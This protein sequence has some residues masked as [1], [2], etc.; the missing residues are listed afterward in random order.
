MLGIASGSLNTVVGVKK[1]AGVDIVLSI[2]SKRAIPS[3]ITYSD[4]ERNYGDQAQE[5]QKSK[6]NTTINYPSRLLGFQPEWEGFQNECKYSLC[7]PTKNSTTDRASYEID[8]KGET[9]TIYPEGAMGTFLNKLKHLFENV[10]TDNKDISISVPD[11][12]TANERQAMIDAVR[13]ADLKL[14]QLV[15]ESSA[16]T[17]NYGLFR[18]SQFDEKNPRIVAFVDIGQSKTSIFFSSFTK[19]NHKV[20]SVTNERHC[21]ARELDY[22]LVEHFAE[23]FNKK[24]GCNPMKNNKC[25]LRMLE[26]VSKGRK[27][28]T[29]NSE[30]NISI[31]SWMEDEDLSYLLKREEFE[32]IISPVIKKMKDVMVKA[33]AESKLTIDQIHSVEMV[34]DAVRTPCIQAAIKEI[35]NL[36]VS[37]TLAPDESIARGTTLFSALS[38]PYFQIKDY[39]F[40]HFNNHTICME[41]P[42]MKEGEVKIRTHKI[43]NR[44][45]NFPCKK[46]IKFTEK[47]LPK[48]NTINIKLSYLNDEVPHMKN[49]NILS[50]DVHIP[51]INA[52]KF[53]LVLHFVMD[54]NGIPSIEKADFNEIWLEDQPADKKDVKNDS[55]MEVEGETKKVEKK[56]A[57][58]CII[59]IVEQNF[60][61][62]RNILDNIIAKEKI[63]EKDD[64]YLKQVHHKRN[65]IEQFIYNTRQ[66][67]DGDLLN[68]ILPEEMPILVEEMKIMEEWFYSGDAG[69]E[70]MVALEGKSKKLNDLGQAIYKR[71]HDWDSVL[72]AGNNLNKYINNSN[73]RINS[74]LEKLSK[75]DPSVY[76]NNDEL[77]DLLKSIDIYRK[78]LQEASS[79]LE[80]APRTSFPPIEAATINQYGQ[81]LDRKI[82]NTYQVA[83]NRFLEAK[84]KAEKE[85]KDREDK[86]RK[87]K[88]EKEKAEKAEK[89][90]KEGAEKKDEKKEENKDINMEVD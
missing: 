68:F 49:S 70:D 2:T 8:Y 14:I 84:R 42:F 72:N 64:L 82:N 55:K 63:L 10:C 67:L 23:M 87:E 47:Q 78:K 18:R 9:L 13:V 20:I 80:K 27:I 90:A 77:V 61:L 41:Y 52:E 30:T 26:V 62:D 34:G 57:H 79:S 69:V 43:T 71:Y 74:D 22:I 85:K 25:I 12:Y 29:G 75:N 81:D 73:N 35:F 65:E 89:A 24:Y 86:E 51:K 66:K 58:Q 21:G 15:N 17:L 33:L 60:A 56:K 45:D 28:L 7:K 50:Y 5:L 38:S 53:E 19:N 54:I 37:K 1:G 40:E 6:I 39:T 59:N 88:E 36:E 44:G 48:E 31:E 16:N 83:E 76:V 3:V 11:Y 46:S 4:K 32:Q